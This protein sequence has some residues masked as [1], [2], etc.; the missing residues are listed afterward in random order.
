MH[1]LVPRTQYIDYIRLGW[2]PEPVIYYK[3]KDGRVHEIDRVQMG[4][5]RDS[6]TRDYVHVPG[7]GDFCSTKEPSPEPQ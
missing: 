7:A 5:M 3:D 2:P 4:V 6:D 1:N